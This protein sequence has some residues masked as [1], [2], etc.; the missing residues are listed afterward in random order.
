MRILVTN[1]P[2][3]DVYA[4]VEVDIE[5]KG[6]KPTQEE[7]RDAI[8]GIDIGPKDVDVS[9]AAIN[10]DFLSETIA[11]TPEGPQYPWELVYEVKDAAP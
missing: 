10:E 4:T 9:E 2:V 5:P 6:D 7:L 11:V 3:V 8:R 1:V